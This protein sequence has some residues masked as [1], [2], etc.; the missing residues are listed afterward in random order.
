VVDGRRLAELRDPSFIYRRRV[1]AEQQ[2]FG[3]LRGRVDHGAVAIGEKPRQ[4]V[5]QALAELVI[6]VCERFVEEHQVG[7]LHQGTGECGALLLAA[8]QLARAAVQERVEPQELGDAT[9]ARFY[10]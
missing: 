6:E 3:R 4:L 7:V 8:G 2:R 1:A 10:L 9:D 5:A